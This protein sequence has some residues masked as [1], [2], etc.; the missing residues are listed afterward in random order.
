[1]MRFGRRFGRNCVV[2]AALGLAASVV[3]AAPAS[4]AAV[5]RIAGE[6][7]YATAAA[8]STLFG[9]GVPIVFVATG[10][11]FPDALAA[12]PAGAATGGPVL[13]TRATSVPDSTAA[14]LD[15]LDP[16]NIVVLGGA[17]VISDGVV[18]ELQ[19]YTAG[20]V[21]RVA[22][23]DRFETAAAVAANFPVG[24]PLVYVANGLDFPDALAAGATAGA[25]DSPLLLVHQNGI[26]AS[27]AAQLERLDPGLIVVAGGPSAVSSDVQGQLFAYSDEVLRESG[28]NR[29]ETAVDISFRTF[30]PGT[31]SVFLATGRNF[32]DALAGGPLAG[33]L[34]GPLLLVEQDCVPQV[35][36]NEINRL[37][38]ESVVLLGGESALS[39]SV[40]ALVP[41]PGPGLP[42]TG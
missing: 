25:F 6:D 32:P 8:V 5:S 4:A 29:F 7:R 2:A 11:N 19:Q 31:R 18:A 10:E 9:A 39:N 15:H 40:A 12:G 22:G 24:V 37:N 23:Q 27:T 20:S 14:A 13:L 42:T 35:V 16:A 17:G 1:M 38:P 21:V 36:I 28:A 26:P 34:I 41:C 3:P 30:D 33:I